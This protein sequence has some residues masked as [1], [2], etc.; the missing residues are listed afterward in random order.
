MNKRFCDG[1]YS[2]SPGRAGVE[3]RDTTRRT[4]KRT[5]AEQ[6]K[7]IPC[8]GGVINFQRGRWRGFSDTDEHELQFFKKT[9]KF[10]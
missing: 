4:F 9:K 7:A 2:L 10:N 8:S 6:K 1:K 5:N 3:R